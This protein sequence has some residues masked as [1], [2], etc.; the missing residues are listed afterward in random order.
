MIIWYEMENGLTNFITVAGNTVAVLALEE[1]FFAA[2]AVRA[3]PV[4]GAVEAVASVACPRVQ[5][6][7]KEAPVR[8][9]ITV[10]S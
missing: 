4:A 8:E 7:V 10:A 3:V 1:V 9:L 6:F 5:L 2:L